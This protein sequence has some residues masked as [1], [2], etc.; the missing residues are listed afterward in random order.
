MTESR[1]YQLD[2]LRV[3]A[4]GLLIPYHTGMIFVT[5]E[6]HIK[7][8]QTSEEL[9]IF[10]LLLNRWR[11][12]LLFLISGAGVYFALRTRSNLSF[13]AERFKRLFI[14]IV[15]GMLVIV[16]PQIYFERLQHGATFSY[17]AFYP[18]VL[19]LQPYP[20]G[21]FSW[22]H[23]WFVVYIFVFSL[24]ALPLF[25]FW[26]SEK[27]KQWLEKLGNFVVVGK[28]IYL[29][30]LPAL[31]LHL[32][33]DAYF[34]TTHNLVSDW[35]NF[36]VSL[37][38]FLLGYI[39]GSQARLL[40]KLQTLRFT[41]LTFAITAYTLLIFFR[42]TGLL[43]LFLEQ[44]YRDI[45]YICIDNAL[46]GFSIF[47]IVGF[48]QKHLTQN[49]PFLQYANRAVYPFYILHQTVMICIGFYII[50]WEIHWFLKFI[51]INIGTFLLS[52]AIYEIVKRTA[53]TRFL[54]GIK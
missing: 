37:Y 46:G 17:A 21:N 13:I 3:L 48:A 41:S 8:A 45:A 19:A 31:L 40:D 22:H 50:Q 6:F 7:N 26:K 29:F 28:R 44:G 52:W 24:L 10:M 11:L 33:L 54:M 47:A 15:F 2:W 39:F 9:E 35:S 27:G 49:S 53:L 5:W 43:K 42:Q 38:I 25:Q 20:Q 12:P 32:C 18:T 34:P 1:K 4:F 16:P 36:S 51:I 30:F 14:P 23:L